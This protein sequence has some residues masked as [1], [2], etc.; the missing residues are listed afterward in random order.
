MAY[1]EDKKPAGLSTLTSLASDDTL[2]VGDTSDPAEVVKTITKSNFITDLST[3]FAAALGADDN[4]MTDAEK[5]KLAGIETAADVTDATNVAAAGA[6]MDGDFSTNGLMKRTGAGTYSV[7][8]DNSTNWD[9]AYGWG[10]HAS[11]GYAA[12][13][14]TPAISSGAGAPASTPSKVGDIYIDT[15]NDDAYIAVGTASSGDWE[16]SNDG[17]G[18]GISDGDKGDITVSASGA[19]WT[20]DNNVVTYAKMQ[21]VSATARVLG[22]VTAGSG[23]VEEIIIDTDLTSVSASDDT[24]AS[25]KAIKTALD[26]KAPLASPSFT[27]TVTLPTGLT[28]VLRADSGVVST[29]S[30][31]TDLVSAASTTVAGKVELAIASEVNTGTSTSLAVTPDSLAG[32][33]A[34]T[35]TVCV[36]IS[37]SASGDTALATGDD[38]ATLAIDTTL[39]GMNLIAVKAYVTTVS[40]SGAPLFQVRRSRRSS[41][42]A[43]TVV[44]M[45]S[46]G[47]SI[48][49]N[50][51]E[52]ADA[53]TAAVIN[54]SNDDVQT[55]DIL[56]F[57]CDTA[58]TG[59]KG[60]TI[61]LTFQL[62]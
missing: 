40:S 29:D 44:D 37:G 8:T 20:I 17:A 39:N 38:K 43:R 62:P 58:G 50:E 35:K 36:Q 51:F 26:A 11:G 53:A 4:Y 24:V 15:T 23:D 49:A 41:A 9:T 22:R 1:A 45:L 52:S 33:Y 6:V 21:D 48:D 30:D 54:T 7:V 28:G 12:A 59:T 61:L 13:S 60:A 16:K 47:V 55:G 32:S 19:T 42:T 56:L 57:D 10:N 2:I 14:T 27:G 31:V 46:T 3:S 25:A 34:G 18:G 5:T